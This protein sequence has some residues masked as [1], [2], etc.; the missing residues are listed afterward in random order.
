MKV[1]GKLASWPP[2]AVADEARRHEKV[3]YDGLWSSESAHDPFLP[4]V[5]A[6]EHLINAKIY[7]NITKYNISYS[8]MIIINM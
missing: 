4:L 1:D 6:A 8:V 3:G 2:A 7:F 5:L